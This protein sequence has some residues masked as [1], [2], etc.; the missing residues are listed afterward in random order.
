[1]A[2]RSAPVLVAVDRSPE[3]LRLVRDAA[4]EA[5]RCASGLVILHACPDTAALAVERR[6]LSRLAV[7]AAGC[8]AETRLVHGT[9][10]AAILGNASDARLLVL[11]HDGRRRARH[12][13]LAAVV[14]KTT[15]P[16]LVHHKVPQAA[17]AVLVALVGSAGT[18]PAVAA[19][20]DA[21]MRRGLPVV[22]L[23]VEPSGGQLDVLARWS[24]NY[25]DVPLTVSHR[26]GLDAAIVVVAASR[27]AALVAV[28]IEP[29]RWAG[30]PAQAIADR[31]HCP[32]LL[33]PSP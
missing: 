23:A 22:A 26:H 6:R 4:D 31:A 1:M 30:S 28:A 9:P 21:A 20:F 33:V 2:A 12:R 8:R 16:V 3:G 19:A 29:H 17:A 25:P 15:C 18:E 24:A 7:A 5:Q 14:A 32:V 13:I 10:A 27:A 11:G